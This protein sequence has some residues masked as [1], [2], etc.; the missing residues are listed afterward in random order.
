MRMVFHPALL[1]SHNCFLP[2]ETRLQFHQAALLWLQLCVLGDKL[3]R[4]IC[5]A[6]AGEAFLPMLVQELEVRR[7]WSVEEH[8]AWLAFEVEGRLQ[9]RPQ[10][11]TIADHMINNPGS[12]VQV[13]CMELINE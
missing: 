7:T 11:H 4:L 3:H 12:I 10:Q 13:I 9:I 1:Q 8:P 2:S 5:F 6:G